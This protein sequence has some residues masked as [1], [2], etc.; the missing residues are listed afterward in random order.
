MLG[1]DKMKRKRKKRKKK[2]EERWRKRNDI[3]KAIQSKY[4][5]VDAGGRLRV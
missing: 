1:K 5:G 3:K 4:A 2:K